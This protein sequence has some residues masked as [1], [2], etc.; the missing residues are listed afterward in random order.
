MKQIQQSLRTGETKVAEV[1]V[2][3][4]QEGQLLIQTSHSL[5]SAGTERMLLEFGKAGWFENARQ[6]TGKVRLVL[7]KIK[8][9]G[10]Q[11][12]IE[13][14][15]EKL[16][17]PLPMGYCNVGKVLD[18]GRD[19]SGFQVGDRVVSNGKHAEAVSVPVNLCAKV[20]DAV[21]DDEAAFTVLGAIALQGIRLAQPTLGETVVVT[22]LGLVGLMTVQLLRAQGCRVLGM[23]LDKDRLALAAQFGT[24]V[25]DLS[26][27]QDPVAAAQAYSRG[28]GVDAVIL[29][30][31]SKSNEPVSQAAKMCR[32]RGR[33]VLVGVTGLELSRADFFEK[34]LTFQVSCSYGPGRYDPNYE[35]K[36]LPDRIR[37]LD[38]AT[39]FRGGPG[40][41]GRWQTGR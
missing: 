30:V 22:G 40:H 34:E 16:D 13:A 17:Q 28:R 4:V 19:T 27:G 24:E 5:V 2:P 36:G 37:A 25:V 33:I 38:G 26:D 11:P 15:V 20:P 31:S 6:H 21:A 35:E 41:D 3:S 14:V 12:T 7:E 10:L 29:T 1:P 9:D 18:K 39:E 8:T 23:D 32:K